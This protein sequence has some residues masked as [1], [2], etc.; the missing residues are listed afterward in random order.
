ML[1]TDAQTG[2]PARAAEALDPKTKELVGIAAAVAGHCQPCFAYHYREA[3]NLGVIVEE[4]QA[5]VE[6]ARAVRSA[7]D[8]HLDEFVTRRMSEAVAAAAQGGANDARG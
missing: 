6:L 3:L 8:R 5:A 2:G 1:Q 7:G 4:I